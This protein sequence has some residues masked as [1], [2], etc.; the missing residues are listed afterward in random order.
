MREKHRIHMPTV[1]RFLLFVTSTAYEYVY[2]VQYGLLNWPK[3]V[4]FSHWGQF[5][6][7][8]CASIMSQFDF[9]LWLYLQNNQYKIVDPN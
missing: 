4:V 6:M 1:R 3:L 7:L 5:N 8:Y 9:C 2:Q